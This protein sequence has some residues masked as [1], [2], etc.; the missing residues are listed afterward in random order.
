MKTT[1]D[2]NKVGIALGGILMAV[3]L[4][5]DGQ[6]AGREPLAGIPLPGGATFIDLVH[7]VTSSGELR[8]WRA[9]SSEGAR[10]M[11]K[12]YRP[13]GG[14]LLLVGTSPLE[15]VAAGT[16]GT[17]ACRIPVARNDVIGCF[18]PDSSCVDAY[19]DG[20]ILTAAGDSG[21]S[22][23]IDFTDGTGSP[24]IFATGSRL[25]DVPS[26]AGTDLVVPAVGRT[27]GVGGTVWS[28]RLEL[29]NTADT[30]TEV[31]L[32][33]NVSDRDNTSPAAS[34]QLDVAPRATLIIE[35]LVSEA[36]GMDEA[37]GSVDI[38]A[39]AP[40]IAHARIANLGSDAGTFGQAVPAIPGSWA[41]GDDDVPGVN[42]NADLVYLFEAQED[43]VFRSNL[44][45][46]SVAATPL[47]LSVI[48]RVG[49]DPVG[50]SLELI[51]DPFSHTQVNRVLAEMGVPEGA[52]G[53]RLEVRADAG[54]GGRFFAYL[55]RVDNG[56]GDAVFLLGDR[57]MALP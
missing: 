30:V 19:P 22:D 4:V 46:A 51:L 7:P 21:T 16:V 55:S 49:S 39:S 57:E 47:S 6:T 52:R 31:A 9:A 54:S 35:D 36:F 26:T 17:F 42:P 2:R 50:S 33:L 53:V 56:S 12:V 25:A 10:V 24:S 29:F 34:A 1:T 3:A 45:V 8:V 48:A 40:V 41:V 18:C 5:A 23:A 20:R 15:T 43:A 14:R 32:H 44:G 27:A 11:L 38:I 28:T 37:V 13:D